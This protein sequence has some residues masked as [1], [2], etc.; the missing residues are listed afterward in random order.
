ML[1][2]EDGFSKWAKL[3]LIQDTCDEQ[4]ARYQPWHPWDP[5]CFSVLSYSDPQHRFTHSARRAFNRCHMI[6]SLAHFPFPC[7]PSGGGV[8]EFKHLYGQLRIPRAA[9]WTPY[10]V[11]LW[12]LVRDWLLAAAFQL[13]QGCLCPFLNQKEAKW[14]KN[15]LFWGYYCSHLQ[16]G[17]D[18]TLNWRMCS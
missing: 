4:G 10:S 8:N 3:L 2:A 5:V 12:R 1:Q 7:P 16:T 18:I 9:S 14:E 17:A 13:S 11:S 15:H 6:W